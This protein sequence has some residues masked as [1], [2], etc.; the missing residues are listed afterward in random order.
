M[1]RAQLALCF[2]AASVA[3]V[4]AVGRV[5]TF[6]LAA[7]AAAAAARETALAVSVEA[8]AAPLL[9]VVTMSRTAARLG[10][11]STR[12]LLPLESNGIHI[13]L[14]LVF[15]E[16]DGEVVGRGVIGGWRDCS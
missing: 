15:T 8:T 11:G 6:V 7:A 2:V 16:W 4:A 14:F 10:S 12:L 5:T 9:A 1:K 3:V 13:R